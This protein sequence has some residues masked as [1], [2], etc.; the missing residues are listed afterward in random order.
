MMKLSA[1]LLSREVRDIGRISLID[2]GLDLGRGT[3]V[4]DFHSRGTMPSWRDW[5]MMSAS[6]SLSSQANSLISLPGI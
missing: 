1:T 5:F 2:G 4:A 6:G 3:T